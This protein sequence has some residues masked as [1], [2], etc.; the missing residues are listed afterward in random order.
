MVTQHDLW[1]VSAGRM[2]AFPH[3]QLAKKQTMHKQLNSIRQTTWHVNTHEAQ[4]SA[5]L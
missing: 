3:M 4:G 5:N 2:P 1:A